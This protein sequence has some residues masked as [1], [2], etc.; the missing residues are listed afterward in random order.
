[1]NQQDFDQYLGDDDIIM[2]DWIRNLFECLL[3]NLTGL[4][5]DLTGLSSKWT[6]ALVV[7]VKSIIIYFIDMA[8]ICSQ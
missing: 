6:C 7:Q 8:Q 3:T 1:M 5:Q 2:F 4:E